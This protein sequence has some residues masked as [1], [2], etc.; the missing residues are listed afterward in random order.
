MLTLI[1]FLILLLIQKIH[2]Y[3]ILLLLFSNKEKA[4]TQK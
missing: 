4:I 3:L 1:S 2:L